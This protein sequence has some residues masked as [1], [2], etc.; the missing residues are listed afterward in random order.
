[1]TGQIEMGLRAVFTFGLLIAAFALSGCG[2]PGRADSNALAAPSSSL[3]VDE[4]VFTRVQDA[5]Q[6]PRLIDAGS[7][8]LFAHGSTNAALLRQLRDNERS[9]YDL[10]W[11]TATD[12]RL[13]TA[14]PVLADGTLNPFHARDIREA[15]NWLIDR[16]HVADELYG[17]LAVPRLLPISGAFPDY[18]R[19]APVAR[20]LEQYYRHDPERARAA[21]EAAMVR[22]GAERRDRQWHFNGRPVRIIAIIR[23]ET[24][25][26]RLGDYVAD[27][28]EGEGFVVE[29]IYRNAA[30]SSRIWLGSNPQD[31]A[32]HLYLGAW[33]AT[34][35][36][37]D[38]A[39]NLS[40][41]YTRRGRPDS[42]WQAFD[43]DP[44]FDA[45][46]ARLENRD[47]R[48]WD[49]RQAWMAQ[50]LRLALQ[51]ST[52]IWTVDQLNV[53][54]RA[55]NVALAVDLAGGVAGSALWPYT[56]RFTDRAGG[57]LVIGSPSLLTA[58]WNPVAGSNWVYD[59]M[60]TRALNDPPLLPDPYTGLFWPQRISHAEVTVERGTPVVRSHDWV[61]LD[62]A[63]RI[64]VADDAW[65][66]WDAEA[67]R[68]ITV[69]ERHP[70]GLQARSRVRITFEDGFLQRRWHDG[71]PLSLADLL[72]PLILTFDRADEASPLHDP[73]HRPAFD[74]F[75]HHFRGWRIVSERPL[76][77][78]VY[79]DQIHPDAETIV[80]AR[81]PALLPWHLI[82]L[83]IEAEREGSLAFSSNKADRIDAEWLSLASGPSLPILRRLLERAQGEGMVPY[84]AVLAPMLEAGEVATRYANLERWQRER[85]HFYVGNGPFTLHRV[86][87]VEGSV[88]LRRNP[89]HPD[90]PQ[91]W[92]HFTAPAIPEPL[93]DGPLI[94]AA[95]QG[96]VFG[97]SVG[98]DGV[99]YPLEAIER[100]DWLL[101]DS[102]HR[103]AA[104]G[105]AQPEPGVEGRWRIE[106][107]AG[108]LGELAV[109]ANT[110]EV[111]V[112]SRHVALPAFAAHSFATLPKRPS[113][114]LE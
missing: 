37:R 109:G 107:G 71:S 35:I 101:F 62:F 95:G 29:R 63:E 79:S 13:N 46:A 50:G 66:D 84:R 65:I 31:G 28:L 58:P 93:L 18:A 42:W 7:H 104:Q 64:G 97:L 112:T 57:R 51:E 11:G 111:A 48:D 91:R 45:L 12:L 15:L 26:R 67:E 34:R 30:E 52:N 106:L 55:A 103:L 40:F 85:G 81:A 74:A 77:V 100:I 90:P 38:Q 86:H 14:G 75:R 60:V 36:V 73:A 33:M 113:L 114:G 23:T 92:L 96:A 2:D 47:Y 10:S 83:A 94:V 5:G 19:L 110:L 17:G 105:R 3:L 87:P 69:A 43:P 24:E 6:I 89:D 59:Q 1:M 25:R 56:L 68:F 41:Y 78:E 39:D 8:H 61:T 21:I 70:D 88:V 98:S 27:L 82:A 76:V 80:A 20:A 102:H 44:A 4:V 9:G 72:L 16:R 54:P 22:L 49:E 108:Q 53:W 99:P 32:W